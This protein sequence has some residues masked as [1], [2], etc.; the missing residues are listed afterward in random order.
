MSYSTEIPEQQRL[1][2]VTATPLLSA[3][4][5]P[6]LAPLRTGRNGHWLPCWMPRLITSTEVS[7]NDLPQSGRAFDRV[8][9]GKMADINPE[10]LI[11]NERTLLPQLRKLPWAGAMATERARLLKEMASGNPIR[12]HR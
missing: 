9:I 1:V 2:H 3:A 8:V 11:A 7:P 4:L 5:E 6:I 10:Q 12:D